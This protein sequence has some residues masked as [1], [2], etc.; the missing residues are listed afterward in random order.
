M[1]HELHTNVKEVVINNNL[2]KDGRLLYGQATIGGPEEGRME[3]NLK[4]G[5]VVNT[6]IH[7]NLHLMDPAMP[8][9]KVYRESD[10]IEGKMSLPQMAHLLMQTHMK[11]QYPE[12]RRE[13]THT[14][15]SNVREQY[16]R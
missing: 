16:I 12:H 5:D 2:K 6:I 8:H 11:S 3:I 4:A 7:E 14:F 15:A 10:K 1:N 9:G 13:I